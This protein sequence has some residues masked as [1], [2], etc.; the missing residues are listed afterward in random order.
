[1]TAKRSLSLIAVLILFSISTFY[2]LFQDGSPKQGKGALI[3]AKKTP[4][5]IKQPIDLPT[6]KIKEPPKPGKP[7]IKPKTVQTGIHGILIDAKSSAP[8]LVANLAILDVSKVTVDKLGRFSIPAPLGPLWAVVIRAPGYHPKLFQAKAIRGFGEVHTIKLDPAK[9]GRLEGQ[10]EFIGKQ[11]ESYTV[12]IGK[13]RYEYPITQDRF[14]IETLIVGTHFVAISGVGENRKNP[15]TNTTI[16]I[17][18]DKASVI[19]FVVPQLMTLSGKIIDQD[20]QPLADAY[21]RISRQ[22]ALSDRNGIFRTGILPAALYDKISIS[23]HQYGWIH[24][25]G[26]F[27]FRSGEKRDDLEFVLRPKGGAAIEGEITNVV[28]KTQKIIVHLLRVLVPIPPQTQE[29]ATLER[30]LILHKAPFQYKF[31]NL[32]GGKYVIRIT[33][34]PQRKQIPFNIEENATLDFDIKLPALPEKKQSE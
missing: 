28:D 29:Q 34:A 18:E 21:V 19:K 6:T 8:I 22:T 2:F 15:V 1:M 26:P 31:T 25:P 4:K 23:H 9:T 7:L 13:E 32:I 10:V 33:A 11:P 5:T 24:F 20:G 3:P 27:D 16:Y 12:Y 14:T 30:S 17:L